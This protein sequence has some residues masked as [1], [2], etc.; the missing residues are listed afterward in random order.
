M[1]IVKPIHDL[2]VLQFKIKEKIYS[3]TTFYKNEIIHT[4]SIGLF[5]CLK[6]PI[7]VFA[8]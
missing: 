3:S 6:M 1:K 5:V 4:N 7:S 8:N 2:V